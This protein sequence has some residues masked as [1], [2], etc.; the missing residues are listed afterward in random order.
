MVLTS[1]TSAAA[2]LL[3]AAAVLYLA[4]EDTLPGVTD[5]L[6]QVL[7]DGGIHVLDGDAHELLGVAERGRP[8]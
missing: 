5:E 4:R 8:G 6:K 7:S 2:G 3:V 1:K